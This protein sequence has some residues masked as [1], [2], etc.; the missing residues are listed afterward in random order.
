MSALESEPSNTAND[1]QIIVNRASYIDIKVP[2]HAGYTMSLGTFNKTMQPIGFCMEFRA[3]AKRQELIHMDIA[4]RDIPGGLQ[5]VLRV[6][7]DSDRKQSMR[8]STL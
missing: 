7:N 1:A 8:V 3:S 5:Y 2:A 4:I 6:V